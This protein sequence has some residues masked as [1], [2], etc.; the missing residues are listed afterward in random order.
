MDRDRAE[1]Q[2]A[3][4]KATK[5]EA[6]AQTKPV[7]PETAPLP[8]RTTRHGAAKVAEPAAKPRRGAATKI[9]ALPDA[10]DDDDAVIEEALT[11]MTKSPK[12]RKREDDEEEPEHQQPALVTGAKLRDYQVAGVEWLITLY[13]NG[14]NGILADEV[15][16]TF[17]ACFKLTLWQM[18][19]GCAFKNLG[20]GDADP[21]SAKP[22][23]P[24]HFWP[25]C[26]K[27]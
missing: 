11:K 6:K 18:G 24:S 12:K 13:E 8:T 26:E 3:T 4:V 10:D 14:L 16:L 20:V 17:C 1:R 22:C 2:A 25:I 5:K 21:L 9:K 7:E 23:R 15:R 27:R 19:L